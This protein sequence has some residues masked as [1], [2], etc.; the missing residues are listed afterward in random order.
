MSF[1]Y[2]NAPGGLSRRSF[3]ATTSSLAAA[4]VWSSRTYGAVRRNLKLADYPFQLGVASGD[5]SADGFVLWTRL[6]PKPL[7]GGGMPPEPV[8]VSWQV[9]DD[10]G[11]SKIVQEGST[12]A[13]PEWAHSAHV[14]VNGLAPDRWY[15]YRFKMGNDESPKARARTMPAAGAT[16]EK[17]RMAFASCQHYESGLYTAYEHM[18]KDDLDLVFHLG[19][20]IYEG[21]A[22]PKGVRKHLGPEIMTLADYRGRYAQ[23][24]TDAL[25]QA[26]HHLAPWIVTWDDHEV[27]NNYAGDIPESKQPRE[28][29]LQRRAQAYQAYYEHMPLRRSCLPKGPDMSLYRR[30]SFGQLAEFHVLDT[31]QYRTDQPRSGVKQTD[32]GGALDPNGTVLGAAQREWLEQGLA[33]SPAKWNVLAQQIM[34]ARVDRAPHEKQSYSMDQWPG[35]EVDRRRVIKYLHDRKISN[36]VVIT[37]DIHSHWANELIADFDDLGSQNVAV[38]FVGT[39]ISSGGD[40]RAEPSKLAELYAENPFVKFHGQQRG[41]VRCTITPGEWRSDYQVVPYISRP[42]APVETKAAFVVEAGQPKLQK[43]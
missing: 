28:E 43:A 18:A 1:A 39:S 26:M 12:T 7:E 8:E 11:F 16:P 29:F 9:A 36:P 33:A 4:A 5:P 15:W 24:K 42:G 10:E 13:T 31:R 32:S 27:E 21:G 34:M 40:G 22:S 14:E 6:A 17:L 38:E 2:R 41:Y 30:A 19:D 23:Y 25:L 35:Y 37:G 20:Y 3:L